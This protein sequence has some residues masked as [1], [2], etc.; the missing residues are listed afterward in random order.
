[1]NKHEYICRLCEVAASKSSCVKRKVGAIFVNDDH[2][3]LVT[4]FN[5]TPRGFSHCD[6]GKTCGKPCEKTIHAEQNAIVQAAKHGTSIKGSIL[7]CTYMPCIDCARLLVNLQVKRVHVMYDN[8][9]G[10]ANILVSAG[11]EIGA[12]G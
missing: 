12:W 1:M 9:D 2:E 4:G 10:G 8:R 6:G 11:I 7:Y 5:E 3:V